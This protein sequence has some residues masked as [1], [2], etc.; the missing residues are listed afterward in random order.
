MKKSDLKQNMIVECRDG[1]RYI[2]LEN[3]ET[4]YYGHQDL[5]FINSDGYLIGDSYDEDL[6]CTNGKSYQP[7]FDIGKVMKWKNF[8]C[9]N[10][11]NE[12]ENN[13]EFEVLW[14]RQEPIKWQ[15]WELEVLKNIPLCF[16]CIYKNKSG[17]T[18]IFNKESG[19]IHFLRLNLPSLPAHKIKDNV[20]FNI[21]EELARYGMK[22]ED[23]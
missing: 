2:V 23:D 14:E 4:L 15:P 22:R 11:L 5:L 7:E 20:W 12:D 16:N 21:D 13:A 3:V 10:H 6:K 1:I 19:Y 17:Y 18:H 8:A 9:I